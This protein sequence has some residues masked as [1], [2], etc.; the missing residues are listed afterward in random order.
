MK[1]GHLFW[2]IILIAIGCLILISNFGWIDFHWSTVWRLWP[3]I[4]IFWGIAILPLKDLIKYALLIGVILFTIIFFNKLTEP[5]GWFLWHGNDS[6]WNFGDEWNKEGGESGSSRR[7]E[8]QTLTVPYDSLSRKADLILEAAAGDFKLEGLTT[9]LLSFSKNGN[10]GNYSLTT[11]DVDGKK[12]VRIHLDKSEGPRKFTQNEVEI[13]LNQQPVWDMNLDIGA[14]SIA[15]D[16]KDY[17]IDTIN[18]NAG[19]SSI[20]LTLGNK[21]P[22]TRVTFNAG[23]SSLNIRIPK[24]AACEVKSESFLV[25]RDFEGFT[26]KG[27]GLYQSDN[28]SSGKNKIYIDI[29]TAV[30]SIT[31]ER[32]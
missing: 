14:A 13:R 8:S 18:I 9:E 23:A 6:E 1:Y 10:V 27:S 21:N 28:Y 17:R 20:D 5:K 7:M 29:Q 4:L 11:E 25:S 24:D 2:A 16:L 32:Y 19:A 12:Q 26:K 15:M 31:I 3:L 22:M 30:S